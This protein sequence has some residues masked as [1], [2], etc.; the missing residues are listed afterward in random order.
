MTDASK[1]LPA[2]AARYFLNPIL[3]SW[4]EVGNSGK[5]V[6]LYVFPGIGARCFCV[7]IWHF[8]SWEKDAT[9]LHMG[10]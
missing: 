1:R 5:C 8:I 3:L 6:F 7:A 4:R 9:P 2:H 10:Y